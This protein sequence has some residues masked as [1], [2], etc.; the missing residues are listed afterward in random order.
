MFDV[1]RRIALSLIASL[2]FALAGTAQAAP[3][4]AD[5]V[6][7]LRLHEVAGLMRNEG[8]SYAEDLQDEM[9]AGGGGAYWIRQVDRIYDTEEMVRIVAEAFEGELSAPHRAAIQA[10]FDNPEGQSILTY[11]NAAREAM[12]DEDVEDIARANYAEL[13]G[14]DDARLEAVKRFVAANDLLERNVA[15]ALGS[16]FMFFQGLADGGAYEFSEDEIIADVWAQEGEIRED[17]EAWLY[18]FLLM[19]YRPLS[20]EMLDRYIAFSETEAGQALNAALFEG[21]DVMYRA[22]S[23]DLGRAAAQAMAG[24][25]L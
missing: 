14:T 15:G 3:T 11:E 12:S 10:F 18:G 21:F 22:I 9:L 7:T 24:S 16:N 17:T 25:D 23:Y 5:L 19:A 4:T 20:D 2:A 8:L 6:Q 13:R 1:T